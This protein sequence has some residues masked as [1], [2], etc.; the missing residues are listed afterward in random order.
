MFAPYLGFMI[1]LKEKLRYRCFTAL[2][3]DIRAQIV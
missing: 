3:P 1:S 2:L